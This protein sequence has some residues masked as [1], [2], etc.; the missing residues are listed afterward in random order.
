M[1]ESY[2]GRISDKLFLENEEATLKTA[3]EVMLSYNLPIKRYSTL[4]Q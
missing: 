1:C 3:A 4:T 2:P